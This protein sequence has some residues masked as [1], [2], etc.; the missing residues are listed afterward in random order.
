MS[1]VFKNLAR[2]VIAEIAVFRL[3]AFTYRCL[4]NGILIEVNFCHACKRRDH[5]E[6]FLSSSVSDVVDKL[7]VALD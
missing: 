4:D 7:F 6:N 5:D 1:T 2:K 3:S